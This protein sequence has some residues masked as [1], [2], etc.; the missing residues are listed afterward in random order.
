MHSRA[1]TL[2]TIIAIAAYFVVVPLGVSAQEARKVYRIG[3]LSASA[4]NTAF[5]QT[6]RELGYVEGKNL[7]F[8]YRQARRTRDYSRLARELVTLK[9][10]L[11][12]T[13]GVSA[14]RAAKD[15]TSKIPI[16]MGNS[17]AD[18]V[19]QG[20]IDSLSNPGGN[21]TGVFDLLP[22][23][24]GKRVEILTEVFP[25]LARIAHISPDGPVGRAH[26]KR[27]QD[28]ARERDI[29]VNAQIVKSP[30]DLE[31]AFRDAAG[32]SFF[33]PNRPRIIDLAA[34]YRLPVIYTHRDW[35]SNGGFIAYTTDSQARY[36]RAAWYVDQIFKGATPAALPVEQP[37]KFLLEINL[38]T[39]RALGITIPSSILLRADEVIE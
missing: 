32:V 33:I 13:V 6:I 14:T 23:L 8:E 29:K 39:A 3:W 19:R 10:D 24:A 1:K 9:P 16:V 5:R 25:K 17:S 21:V 36:S 31:S 22:D 38:R 2:A 15:A 18:P 4:I 28:A 35:V 11:L 26:L 27:V 12:F 30:D 7:I 37:R 34:R 20:L